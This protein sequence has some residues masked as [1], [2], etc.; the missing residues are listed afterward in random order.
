MALNRRARRGLQPLLHAKV[1]RRHEERSKEQRQAAA[2][3]GHKRKEAL[4]KD[5]QL[6]LGRQLDVVAD[7]ANKH[8]VAPDK[9]KKLLMHYR[10]STKA[11]TVNYWN[12]HFHAVSMK[13]NG[14]THFEFFSS[15]FFADSGLFSKLFQRAKKRERTNS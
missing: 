13:V 9:V 3:K 6:E 14:C 1:R 15:F 5:V 11:A 8:D 7:L 12:I 4:S 10:R 2:I